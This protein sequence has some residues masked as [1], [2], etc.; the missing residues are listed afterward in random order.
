ML[1]LVAK[2]AKLRCA[3]GTSSCSL[4]VTQID[5]VV[6]GNAI[7]NVEDHKPMRNIEG[8]GQCGSMQNPAVVAATS[9]ANGVLTMVKCVPPAFTEWKPGAEFI[10]QDVGGRQVRAL[11]NDSKCKCAF[12][13]EVEIVDPATELAVEG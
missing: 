8:F 11:T 1:R 5:Y 3:K 6:D 13:E 4:E 10:Y 9:A 12:G 7:A 2:G